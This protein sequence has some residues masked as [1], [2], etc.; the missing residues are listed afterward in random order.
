[1]YG[2]YSDYLMD[3]ALWGFAAEASLHVVRLIMGGVFDAFPRLTLV[4]GHMGEGIPFWLDR[5]DQVASRT[6]MPALQR[7][8]SEYFRSNVVITTSAMFLG[9]G[10]VA[11]HGSA[12]RRSD[13]VC[14]G[15]ALRLQSTGDAVA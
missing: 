10:A 5:L 14:R 1:M 6:G 13:H 12:G 2:A 9:S 7:R 15:F 3:R 8:P 4:L 11:V